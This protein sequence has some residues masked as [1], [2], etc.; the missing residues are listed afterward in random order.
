MKHKY[1]TVVFFFI[2]TL[3]ATAQTPGGVDKPMVWSHDSISVRVSAGPGLTYIGVS[4]VYGEKEQAI[5]SLG[6][7]KAI[8]RIQ[9]TERAANLGDGTFMNYAKDSLPEMRLYS[10]TTSSNMGNGQTLHIGR[11]GNAKLP[12][13]NLDGRTVEYTVF[14]RRLSDTERCRVESYLALKYGVSLRS[15]YLNSRSEV[16]WNGYTNKDYSHRIAG[17]I[18]DR[19][20][21]LHKTRAKSC[22]EDGFLTIS[23]SKPLADGESYSVG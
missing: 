15:S 7:G 16:I 22:E 10:Y 21:A 8:T 9:T 18:S 14:D 2:S 3:Y 19:A 4:K 23:M 12:V 20:S 11:N 6:N 5:W 13:K 17:L 1:F